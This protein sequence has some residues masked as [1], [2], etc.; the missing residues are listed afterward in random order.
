MSVSTTQ[1]PNNVKNYYNRVRGEDQAKKKANNL[2][3]ALNSLKRRKGY[4][5]LKHSPLHPKRERKEEE[6]RVEG[7]NP[8]VPINKDPINNDPYAHL[9]QEERANLN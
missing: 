6:N 8:K 5:P 2:E 7:L 3:K 1:E 4:R 9:T